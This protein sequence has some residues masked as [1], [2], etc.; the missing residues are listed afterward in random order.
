M[1]IVGY[2][3]KYL[4]ERFAIT[5]INTPNWADYVSY[6]PLSVNGG[7]FASRQQAERALREQIDRERAHYLRRYRDGSYAIPSYDRDYYCDQVDRRWSCYEVRPAPWF[8]VERALMS[9]SDV[10][11]PVWVREYCSP[12]DNAEAIALRAFHYARTCAHDPRLISYYD[13]EK[14]GE[15]GRLTH[16]KPGRYLNKFF[17]AYMTREQIEYWAAWQANGEKPK[18][19]IPAVVLKFAKTPDEIVSVYTDSRVRSCMDGRNFERD[20]N[21]VR[22]Y[23]AGTLAVAALAFENY[24]CETFQ[25]APGTWAP[26]KD[27]YS[28]NQDARD[29]Y[30]ARALCNPETLTYGRVYP[31]L[32]NWSEEGFPD[33]GTAETIRNELIE[34]LRALGY[35][36]ISERRNGFDGAELLAIKSGGTVVMPYLDDAAF[37]TEGGKIFLKRGGRWSGQSTSGYHSIDPNWDEDD[38]DAE[39]DYDYY[40]DE[41]STGV[42]EDDVVTLA[43]SMS[44][45][46]NYSNATSHFCSSCGNDRS[47][48]CEGTS[49]DWDSRS[50]D[51]VELEDGTIWAQPYFERNGGV[52]DET[53]ENYSDDDLVTLNDGES[54]ESR[55]SLSWAENNAIMTADGEWRTKDKVFLCG[56]DGEYYLLSEQSVTYPGFPASMDADEIDA[57]TRA[58]YAPQPEPCPATLSLNL[59]D[60]NTALHGFVRVLRWLAF[61]ASLSEDFA[62]AA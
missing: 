14:H 1:F 61:Q 21:P 5:G 49:E 11:R 2:S 51:M 40:C 17:A 45:R 37:D 20:R 35:V 41:C 30:V 3:E 10:Q 58:L 25:G 34:R 59:Y 29:I 47:F 13:S 32:G 62:L 22:V 12:L 44:P 56:F 55:V 52:C 39:P 27:R 33:E 7:I 8:A 46:G 54:D 24:E 9:A 18:T 15:A 43:T 48:Y 16:V 38:D 42:N 4:S 36:S 53:G 6:S 50:V 23:G 31:T 28:I 19:P 57:E 60:T 26:F